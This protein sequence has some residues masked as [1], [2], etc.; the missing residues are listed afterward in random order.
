MADFKYPEDRILDKRKDND[1]GYPYQKMIDS[2]SVNNFFSTFDFYSNKFWNGIP[3]VEKDGHLYVDRITPGEE[4]LIEG[5]YFNYRINQE[6][7]RSKSFKDFHSNKTNVLFTG[8]SITAGVGMPED[9]AWPNKL[10]DLISK[11]NTNLDIESYNLAINGSGIFLSIKNLLTFIKNVGKPDYIF[12]LFP[13]ISRSFVWDLPEGFINIHYEN[14]DVRMN[15]SKKFFNDTYVHENNLMTNIS[16]IN[17]LEY[18][19]S[20]L[21]IKLIWSTW[22]DEDMY[23]YEDC[24][25]NNFF[26]LSHA[27]GKNVLL[28]PSI[29]EIWHGKNMYY[30]LEYNSQCKDFNKTNIYNEDYY[31]VARDGI[32]PG[33]CSTQIIAEDFFKEL[34]RSQNE[35]N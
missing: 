6:G 28:H 21:D 24:H 26:K 25:L 29:Y 5:K 7:F 4:S 16:M 31:A 34:V 11:Q 23:I 14:P 35:K 13:Q 32:H 9:L 19:C 3:Y 12:A 1:S 2:L 22:R 33:S 18:I 17:V 10:I 8:C 27:V 20:I 30:E 15:E